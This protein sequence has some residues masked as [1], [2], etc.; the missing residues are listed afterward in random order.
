MSKKKKDTP[1]VFLVLLKWLA[2]LI[3]FVGIVFVTGTAL[4]LL[5]YN[6]LNIPLD[7]IHIAALIASFI[8]ILVGFLLANSS[9]D[10]VIS[11]N[12]FKILS[13]L[14]YLAVISYFDN[15]LFDY[16]KNPVVDICLAIPFLIAIIYKKFYRKMIYRA[17]FKKHHSVSFYSEYSNIEEIKDS[18]L[19]AV[20]EAVKDGHKENVEV[21]GKNFRQDAKGNI[22]GIFKISLARKLF[23]I[24]QPKLMLIT[25]NFNIN[26]NE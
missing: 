6:I 22:I 26:N 16:L 11:S 12:Y 10:I 21:V 20:R 24:T 4:L 18:M 2:E 14:G 3:Y 13:A 25:L 17:V 19:E 8:Y 7:Y 23:K 5:T 15:Q 1:L 9:E